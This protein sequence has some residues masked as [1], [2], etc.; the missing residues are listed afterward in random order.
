[1]TPTRAAALAAVA[2]LSL[3]APAAG[4][5]SQESIIQDDPKIVFAKPA[6]L[7]RTLAELRALG[8][9][10]IRVSV[11]WDSLA[12]KPQSKTKPA[13]RGSG[14]ADPRSY[15]ADRWDR[16]DRIAAS[17]RRHGLAVIFNVT[18]PAPLWATGRP[19]RKDLEESYDVRPSDF[20]EFV[21]A[22][23]R[24][25][26][27]SYEDER[28]PP[29]PPKD[30][31]PIDLPGPLAGEDEE[32]PP[33]PPAGI[34]PRVDTWSMWNEPNVPGW[35]TPQ[36]VPDP[37]G[38]R[39]QLHSSPRIFRNLNDAGWASL[40]A[41]GH[42][43]DTFL[44]AETGPRGRGKQGIARGM[45]PLEFV[46]ELYC[47][48]RRSKPYRGE[49]A[50]LRGCP[51]TKAERA[52]FPN[53]HPGL[54]RASG[55]AHHPYALETTPSAT[56]RVKDNVVMSGLSR[57]T[58]TLDRAL[59]GY[60]VKRRL[61]LWITE[62]GYQTNPP[63]PTIGISWK[64]QAAFLN[65]ADFIGYRNKRVAS[66]AQY[67]LFDDAPR[68][69]YSPGDP[70]Y[71]GTFQSGL[72]TFEGRKKS[73]YATYQRTIHVSPARPRSGA[74]LRVFGQLRAGP[75]VP[76]LEVRLEFAR[77]GGAYKTVASKVTR[78][79]RRFALLSAKAK[80]S[81]SYR[82]VWTQPATGKPLPTRAVK[83]SVRRRR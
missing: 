43:G 11:F 71:W 14:A 80:S 13:F 48:N 59:R 35:L 27:G 15:D 75:R 22:V 56:D 33:E 46:R 18:G 77:K 81:G 49:D 82:L 63:D 40:Q 69:G 70:G 2:A 74:K 68:H 47:L 67:Q 51:R 20:G 53:K 34:V 58:R 3:S 19:E 61:P 76:A 79:P 30:D 4:S 42:A 50:R 55:W 21:A 31:G 29:P 12:P 8:A 9:D 41:T 78:N 10:R 73:A 72:V 25:Y 39:R 64:R 28:P 36:W 5:P 65:E 38:G 7:E 83:V 26:S 16:Y 66:V 54:F 17:A 62:Y 24:R 60:G 37:R 45:R 32:S 52:A 1:M 6:A 57:L 23:G 44:L